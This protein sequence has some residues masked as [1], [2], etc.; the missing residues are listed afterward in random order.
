MFQPVKLLMCLFCISALALTVACGWTADHFVSPGRDYGMPCLPRY[1]RITKWERHDYFWG[2]YDNPTGH[3]GGLWEHEFV[4]LTADDSS[5]ERVWKHPWWV[6][7]GGMAPKMPGDEQKQTRFID[8]QLLF[9]VGSLV[10]VDFP[11]INDK[12]LI[13]CKGHFDRDCEDLDFHDHSVG[14]R[15]PVI[16]VRLVAE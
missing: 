7:T 2:E 9:S 14:G 5:G 12:T 13:G 6:G 8:L 4:L 16:I 3:G 11:R 1:V 10:E 15:Y